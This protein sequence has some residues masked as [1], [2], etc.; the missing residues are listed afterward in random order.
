MNQIAYKTRAYWLGYLGLAPIILASL[1][2]WSDLYRA[3]A[4]TVVHY[5]SAIILTFVGAIHWGKSMDKLD[6]NRLTV[7][8][9]PSLHAFFCLLQPVEIALP[10]LAAGFIAIYWY[11]YSRRLESTW[12]RMLRQRLTASVSS[13]LII[14]WVIFQSFATQ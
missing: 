6:T 13:I 7:S 11:E 4:F 9:L 12:F 3:L 8:V 5:Y 1:L 10:L 2:V 14:N